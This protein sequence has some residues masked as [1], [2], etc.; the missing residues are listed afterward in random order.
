MVV[1]DYNKIEDNIKKIKNPILVLKDN[2]YK[3]GIKK[4]I[5]IA[6]KNNIYMFAVNNIN[7]AYTILDE[8]PKSY[9]ILLGIERNVDKR[10]IYSVRDMD[11]FVFCLNN[12]LSFH[13]E[14]NI[15]M[16]RFGFNNINHTIINNKLCE[17]I[18]FHSNGVSYYDDLKIFRSMLKNIKRR[19]LIYHVGGSGFNNINHSLNNRVGLEIYNDAYKV[20]ADVIKIREINKG[21]YVG[22]S[23]TYKTPNKMKIAILNIGYINGLLENYNYKVIIKNKT[24]E[25]VGKLCMDYMFIKV[26][27]NVMLNDKALVILDDVRSEHEILVNMR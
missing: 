5:S 19:D 27:E 10:L 11:D 12:K 6:I 18:Y 17:G 22:Y 2:A 25:S 1:W 14:I 15:N 24:Y 16:N 7:E 21:E 8:C 4:I 9:I 20:Y 26:D 13:Y 3:V 23:K